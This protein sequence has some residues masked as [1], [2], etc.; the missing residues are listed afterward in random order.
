M[1]LASTEAAQPVIAALGALMIL[2]LC[3]LEYRFSKKRRAVV[4]WAKEPQLPDQR[5]EE[6]GLEGESQLMMQQLT[7]YC[8]SRP[9][10]VKDFPFGPEPLVAKVGG[11]MFA[12]IAGSS[13][14]LKCD[15][16]I[17]ANLREQ[18]EAVTPGYHLNK[19]HWNSVHIDGSIPLDELKEMVDHSYYLVVGRL[20]KAQREQVALAA[21]SLR[22]K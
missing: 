11:K 9:G 3:M 2:L 1:F 18:H 21:G 5:Q 20:T 10:A 7:A 19:K 6:G 17:A 14:S 13:I 8:L 22:K 16:F 4:Y 12:L 15:P